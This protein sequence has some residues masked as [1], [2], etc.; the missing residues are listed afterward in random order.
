LVKFNI[1]KSPLPRHKGQELKVYREPENFKEYEKRVPLLGGK[2]NKW[3]TTGLL[4]R[5]KRMCETF[6][7]KANKP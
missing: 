1:V 4:K 3:T 2:I 5:E 7:R 6:C